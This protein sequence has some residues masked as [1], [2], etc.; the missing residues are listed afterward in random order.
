MG[1]MRFLQSPLRR[2]S[3]ARAAAAVAAV[4]LRPS[5]VESVFKRHRLKGLRW[6]V[7]DARGNRRR[8]T[9]GWTAA[10]VMKGPREWL[11][12]ALMSTAKSE[13]LSEEE[14]AALVE[15]AIAVWGGVPALWCGRGG[16]QSDA[17]RASA[18]DLSGGLANELSEGRMPARPGDALAFLRA[19]VGYLSREQLEE[20]GVPKLLKAAAWAVEKATGAEAQA[21]RTD[22]WR[23]TATLLDAGALAAGDLDHETVLDALEACDAS[24]A[25]VAAVLRVAVAV[26]AAAPPP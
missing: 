21:A 18:M 23:L 22:R 14:G 13:K 24:V 12:E 19:G 2:T 5:D 20:I 1:V 11:R 9:G 3:D 6:L 17:W 16:L 7:A 25:G 10:V 26:I 15:D 8:S 4:T